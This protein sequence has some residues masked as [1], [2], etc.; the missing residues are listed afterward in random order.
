MELLVLDPGPV[1]ETLV[2]PGAVD[3]DLGGEAL[4]QAGAGEIPGVA[5]IDDPVDDPRPAD[6]AAPGPELVADA[7]E[8]GSESEPATAPYEAGREERRGGG[9]DPVVGAAPRQLERGGV[10]SAEDV[11]RVYAEHAVAPGI[12][13]AIG[14]DDADA[15]GAPQIT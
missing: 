9:A 6:E 11:A 5:G 15:G 14:V 13:G 7:A 10:D 8:S 4:Q 2:L 3:Q 12:L 1:D